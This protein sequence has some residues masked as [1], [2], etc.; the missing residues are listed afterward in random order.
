MNA[1][2][3]EWPLG[4]CALLERAREASNASGEV[5][6]LVM[7]G[8]RRV[9]SWL[10]ENRILPQLRARGLGVLRLGLAFSGQEPVA[11][12][13]LPLPDASAFASNVDGR[14]SALEADEALAAIRYIGLRYAPGDHWIREFQ[15][16]L[17]HPDG[18]ATL[19]APAAVADFWE[20]VTGRR[21]DGFGDGVIDQ[22][23]AYG[24]A[25]I[26]RAFNNQGQLGL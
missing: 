24:L 14:W 15:A 5:V 12:A 2:E 16:T 20:E 17:E 26:D 10:I 7:S 3:I 11:A 22:M 25:V 9:D 1:L 23:E 19:L 4:A 18:T 21:P 6:R 8:I 13:I